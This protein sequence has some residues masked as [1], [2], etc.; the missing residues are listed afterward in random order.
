M[1]HDD[2]FDSRF[3]AIAK[4]WHLGAAMLRD[5][6][7][8]GLV[9]AVAAVVA[10]VLG[11]LWMAV[12]LFLGLVVGAITMVVLLRRDLARSRKDAS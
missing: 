11:G 6:R 4:D 7:V 1:T 9:W 5:A 2:D 8:V 12:A 10:S 3:E